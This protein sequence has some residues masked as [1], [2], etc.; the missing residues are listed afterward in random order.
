MITGVEKY[1]G[2]WGGGGDHEYINTEKKKREKGFIGD[3]RGGRVQ[4][5]RC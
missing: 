2:V 5:E 3:Y 1:M 4:A